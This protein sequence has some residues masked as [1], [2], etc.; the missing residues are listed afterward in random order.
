MKLAYVVGIALGELAQAKAVAFHAKKKG[1]R[2]IFIAK[3]PKLISSIR[4]DSFEVVPT[5]D[6]STTIKI[7]KRIEPD[8]L[9]MCN[10]KSVSI[11]DDPIL[12][13][14]PLPPKPLICSLDSNWLFTRDKRTF[15]TTP[16]WIDRIYVVMPSEIYKMGLE[17]NG[18]HYRI[19]K[20]FKDKIHCPGFVPSGN[21]VSAVDK[22]RARKRLGIGDNEKLIF[23]YFGFLEQILAPAFF[24]FLSE[25]I[26]E[27]IQNKRRIKVLFKGKYPLPINWDWVIQREWFKTEQ[28]FNIHLASADLVIQ[29][30]GLGTLPKVIR[31]QV[32]AICLVPEIEKDLPYYKHSEYFEI[33]PF[34]RLNLCQT[35]TMKIASSSANRTMHFFISKPEKY[36]INNISFSYQRLKELLIDLLYN[37]EAI[38]SLRNAQKEFFAGGENNIYQDLTTLLE[39][40]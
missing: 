19:P 6:T 15:F 8:I 25:V 9:F 4:L 10:S 22:K 11:A 34:E 27:F 2:N 3:E 36:S 40:Y 1:D 24:P 31:N 37:E 29:H 33:Q 30:H 38:Q 7:I 17:E 5:R 13:K 23:V 39:S 12:D 35:L 28:E 16:T 18:G 26:D 14:P 21:I 32:P 20:I